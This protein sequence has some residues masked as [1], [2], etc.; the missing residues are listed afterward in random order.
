MVRREWKHFE[1]VAIP[2]ESWGRMEGREC[3]VREGGVGGLA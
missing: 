1:R 2:G 3:V